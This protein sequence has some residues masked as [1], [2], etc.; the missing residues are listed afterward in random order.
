MA[1]MPTFFF[2]KVRELPDIIPLQVRVL[3]YIQEKPPSKRL[4]MAAQSKSV[5]HRPSQYGIGDF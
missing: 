2:V 1:A 5:L 4:M 3:E